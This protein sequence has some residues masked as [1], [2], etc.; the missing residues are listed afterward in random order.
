MQLY[1][2]YKYKYKIKVPKRSSAEITFIQF[3]DDQVS[4]VLEV[5]M[6]DPETE[7]INCHVQVSVG[8]QTVG[9][10]ATRSWKKR[11]VHY[12]AIQQIHLFVPETSQIR[13]V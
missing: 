11:A 10:N 7:F 13:T 6:Q 8:V 12:C 9:G 1:V 2:F 3:G 4:S 5:S